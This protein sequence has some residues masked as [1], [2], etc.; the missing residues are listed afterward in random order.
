VF[1]FID[2]LHASGVMAGVELA[3]RGGHGVRAFGAG[4][5]ALLPQPSGFERAGRAPAQGGHGPGP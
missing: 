5:Q 1:A 4:L 3:H 2:E